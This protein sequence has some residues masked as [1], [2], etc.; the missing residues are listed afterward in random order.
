MTTLKTALNG[1]ILAGGRSKRMGQDKSLLSYHGKPQ[2]QYAFDLL[3]PFCAEVFVSTRSDQSQSEVYKGLP[4]LHDLPQYNDKGPIGGIL[5][6]M[7]LYPEAAWLIL[8]GDLPF[9]SSQTIAYLLTQRDP[10]KLATAFVST[11][12][13]LPEPLCAV[14]EPH[15]AQAIKKFLQEGIQCPRKVLIKSQAHLVQQKDPTWLD[16]V[17]D[18]QEFARAK[19]KLQGRASL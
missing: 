13:G 5:S 12:D 3:R 19:D 16:N 8:A 15:A 18:P 2:V 17:N 9:V 10:A 7:T 14:W 1:L 4:Q 6:A 11:H